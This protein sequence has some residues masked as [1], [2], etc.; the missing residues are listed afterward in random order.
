MNAPVSPASRAALTEML[1]ASP[2]HLKLVWH[3]VR[4]H[5]ITFHRVLQYAGPFAIGEARPNFVLLGD[6]MESAFGPAAF[7]RESLKRLFAVC[8]G[9]VVVSCE[10]LPVLYAAAVSVA[11]LNRQHTCLIETRLEYETDWID[12]VRKV[13]P[14][15]ALGIGTVKGAGGVH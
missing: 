10:A 11:V 7:D 3:A 1:E 9:V 13:N 12:L 5:G 15:C 6:D 8:A 14:T 2:P 4:D